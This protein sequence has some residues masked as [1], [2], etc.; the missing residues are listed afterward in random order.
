MGYKQSHRRY[1]NNSNSNSHWYD[2]AVYT[3]QVYYRPQPWLQVLRFIYPIIRFALLYIKCLTYGITYVVG[4]TMSSVILLRYASALAFAIAF[5]FYIVYLRHMIAFIKQDVIWKTNQKWTSLLFKIGCT[6][7]HCNRCIYIR[8]RDICLDI[9]YW[10]YLYVSNIGCSAYK[11]IISQWKWP[12]F[13]RGKSQHI[14]CSKIIPSLHFWHMDISRIIRSIY[15]YILSRYKICVDIGRSYHLNWMK[16]VIIFLILAK[17][18]PG[19][20]K[21]NIEDSNSLV[22]FAILI[23]FIVLPAMVVIMATTRR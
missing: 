12:I 17:I 23:Y 5:I 18:H 7:C 11:C 4:S 21:A 16:R 19:N 1:N 2:E 9:I 3:L 6:R 22:E 20:V 13:L 10:W 8:M 15:I 14:I